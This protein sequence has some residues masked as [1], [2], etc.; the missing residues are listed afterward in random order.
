M[1]FEVLCRTRGLGQ[2]LRQ[3]AVEA[4]YRLSPNTV[5]HHRQNNRMMYYQIT[6]NCRHLSTILLPSLV[7]T[8]HPCDN[9]RGTG[10]RYPDTPAISDSLLSKVKV[11]F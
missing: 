8:L 9:I 1:A 10:D 5:A 6:L 7:P 11:N 2:Y 4:G 3:G